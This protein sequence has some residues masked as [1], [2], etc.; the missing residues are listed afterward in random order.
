M[1]IHHL[2]L[3]AISIFVT[4]I[5]LSMSVIPI[6]YHY[7]AQTLMYLTKHVLKTDDDNDNELNS[8][9]KI[10][11]ATTIHKAKYVSMVGPRYD[12]DTI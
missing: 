6:P 8:D 9:T 10:K 7:D 1:R 5:V 11:A 4:E 12:D 2:L 3:F